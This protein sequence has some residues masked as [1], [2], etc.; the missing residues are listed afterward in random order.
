MKELLTPEELAA[1]LKMKPVTIIRKARKGE[2]PAIKIDKLFRFDKGQIDRWLLEKSVGRAAHILVVDDD[3]FI[4]TVFIEALTPLN[5][6]VTATT[7]STE[8]LEILGREQF[9]LIF[10]DLVMPE[11]DGNELYGRIR[12]LDE[13]VP[14]VIITGY[15]D[16]EL[17]KKV[18][19][20]GTILVM[21]KP[22]DMH[23][24]IRTVRSF[25]RT[26]KVRKRVTE[27]GSKIPSGE[28]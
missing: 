13:N 26:Q 10:L 17:L 9:D 7:S 15:P 24:V 18:M 20:N 6:R 4:G 12:A 2:I 1:Y 11:I 16:S 8:A 19:E 14:V 5:Y 22:L 27:T 3:P 25:I 23:D 28:R 21:N